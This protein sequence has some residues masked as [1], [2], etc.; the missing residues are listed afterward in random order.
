MSTALY[1]EWTCGPDSGF[2]DTR[3]SR[4][5]LEAANQI[6]ELIKGRS[7]NVRPILEF[8]ELINTSFALNSENGAKN[9]VDSGAVALFLQASDDQP[10]NFPELLSRA[11]NLATELKNTSTKSTNLQRL[12]DFCLAISSAARSFCEVPYEPEEALM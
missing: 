1:S 5:A 9:F 8:A 12:R 4:L 6:D 10:K 2:S 11:T 7:F 3:V